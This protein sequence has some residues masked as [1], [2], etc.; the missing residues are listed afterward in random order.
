MQTEQI[1]AYAICHFVYGDFL[2]LSELR[3]FLE[4][5]FL[6]NFIS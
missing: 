3:Y 6:L 2:L 5:K 1:L 4:K